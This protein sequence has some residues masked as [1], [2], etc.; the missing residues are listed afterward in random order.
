LGA[1]R[2]DGSGAGSLRTL[3]WTLGSVSLVLVTASVVLAVSNAS[4]ASAGLFA[5]V[6]LVSL[7]ALVYVG[8]GWLIEGRLSRNPIGWL[9][10]S[11]GIALALVMFAEQYGL[12]ALVAAPGSL[13]AA[14]YVASLGNGVAVYLVGTLL[15]VVLLFPDGRPLSPRW[16]PLVWLA[17]IVDVVGTVGFGLQRTLVTGMTNSLQDHHVAFRNAL[18]LYSSHG[19]S[20]VALGVAGALGVASA[21][22]AIVQLFLRRRRG[23]PELRRQLAWL[24]YVA[25]I[26]LGVFVLAIPFGNSN[27]LL[28]T[29][30]WS[31][32]F[33][34]ILLG[35][36]VACGIAVLRYRLYELDIVVKKTLVFGALAAA[37]TLVYVAIVVGIGA[38]VG[39]RGNATLTLVAAAVV[40]LAFQPFRYRARRFADR[41][42][43][44]KRA[45]PYEVVSSFA[46]RV[47]GTYSTEDVLPRMAQI[48]AAGT[49]AARADVWLRVGTE[50]RLAARW[51]DDDGRLAPSP[52]LLSA[53]DE[54]PPI[55]GADGA[56]PV[57]HRGELLGAIAVA[58]PPAEPLDP[59]KDKLIADMAAQAGLVLRN[60]RLIEELRASRERLVSAQD[61]ER[62]RI[63]RNIHDGAQQQLVALAVRMRLVGSILQHDAGKAQEILAQAESDLTEAVETLRELARGVYP[64]LLAD[65]GLTEA[66]RAQARK[67]ALPVTVDAEGIGRYPQSVEAAAYFCCLEAMQNVAK[68]AHAEEA[69]VRLREVD[70]SLVFEVSDDGEGFDVPSSPR[71]TG[72]Q[73]MADRVETLGGSLEVRSAPRAGTTVTGR[74]PIRIR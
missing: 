23:T 12:R 62:R 58:M 73:G 40:T 42:V 37:F 63:E 44:G 16:R 20:A 41:L 26:A 38:A 4:V 57:R 32:L 28:G 48:V 1:V 45:T 19:P 39:H 46:D 67:A 22:A 72:I 33:I 60:V 11:I 70:G 5:V 25:V 49:G 34:D 56:F 47:G 68:Y 7:T 6:A 9:L 27:G 17:V 29:L 64:P 59:T 14:R 24:G 3:R 66:L 74:L 15:L 2:T 61:A 71:G 10:S 50:L 31:A 51:P 53:D 8:V 18:A 43:Y 21:G 13:P 55:A 65:M 35:I 30:L 36:P 52:G 69:T 54:L